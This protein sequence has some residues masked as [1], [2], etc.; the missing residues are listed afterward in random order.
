[1]C[2]SCCIR[3]GVD[4]IWSTRVSTVVIYIVEIR[5]NCKVVV[6]IGYIYIGP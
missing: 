5:K 1:M 4:C 3:L 2:Y 6:L